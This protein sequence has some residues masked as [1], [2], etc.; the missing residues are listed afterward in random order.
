[1]KSRRARLFKGDQ[2]DLSARAEGV[3]TGSATRLEGKGV[4]NH[5]QETHQVKRLCEVFFSPLANHIP[6]WTRS[7]L[8]AVITF[9]KKALGV[10]IDV[11]HRARAASKCA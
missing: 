7:D 3:E 8:L 6:K 10:E 1:L 5:W 2:G 9:E 4:G 11:K